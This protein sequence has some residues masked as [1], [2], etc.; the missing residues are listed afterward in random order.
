MRKCRVDSGTDG[1][2]VP[3][4][5]GDNQDPSIWDGRAN[6]TGSLIQC[7]F[8]ATKNR[9]RCTSTSIGQCGL[10]ADTTRSPR[11]QNDLVAICLAREVRLWVDSR[12]YADDVSVL[13]GK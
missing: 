3:N 1:L 9:H 7:P 13:V 5:C 10:R 6:F 2:R 12:V 11:Y 4:V 8:L